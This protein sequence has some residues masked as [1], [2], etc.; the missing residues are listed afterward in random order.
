MFWGA[1]YWS[2]RTDLFALP[3]DPES[4]GKGITARVILATLKAALP[5]IL[6]EGIFFIQ[7][8]AP[9]HQAFIMQDWLAQWAEEHG[10]E[11]I[12][13]PA[14][15][16]DL[17]PIENIWKLLKE[18]IMSDFPELVD[19]P[20]NKV[21]LDKLIDAAERSWEALEDRVF[22]AEIESMPRRMEA[23]IAARG[24]YTKY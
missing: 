21:T 20:K 16:P 19:L 6:E 2:S 9:T 23:I 12:D 11:I 15:S 24:W 1:F 3:G 10:V 17:N 14:Y 13:W 22:Q 4:K 5:K 18:K 8:N 7:D